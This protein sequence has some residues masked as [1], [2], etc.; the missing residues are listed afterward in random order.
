VRFQD[1]VIQSL[2][3]LLSLVCQTALKLVEL[4]EIQEGAVRRIADDFIGRLLSQ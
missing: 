3:Q 1:F 2:N 4:R